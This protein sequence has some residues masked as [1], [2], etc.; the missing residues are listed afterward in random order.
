MSVS[1]HYRYVRRSVRTFV[2]PQE[3]FF[4]ISMKFPV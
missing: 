4:P 3:V 2:R 1:T